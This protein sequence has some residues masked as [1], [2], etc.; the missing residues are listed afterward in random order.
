L[1]KFLQ[2]DPMADKYASATTYNYAFNNPVVINDPM[3]DDA[4]NPARGF[5]WWMYNRNGTPRNQGMQDAHAGGMNGAAWNALTYGS[6]MGTSIGRTTYKGPEGPSYYQDAAL[7]RS[8]QMSLEEYSA[9]YGSLS[10]NFAVTIDG[11]PHAMLIYQNEIDGASSLS[12]T[13]IDEFGVKTGDTEILAYLPKTDRFTPFEKFLIGVNEWNPVAHAYDLVVHAF[14]GTDR[15][16]NELSNED[17]GF[18]LLALAPFG[19]SARAFRVTKGGG[20]SLKNISGSLDDA[21]KLARNQPYGPNKNIFR[22]LPNSAQDTQ[23]LLEAQAGMGRN[24]NITLKDPRYLGWEKWHHSLG[25]N[26]N[27]SVV[28]YLRDPKT[29][30]LTDFKFK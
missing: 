23:A 30:F 8:N 13:P 1:G 5:Q 17:L 6:L 12:L 14:T 24:L 29:G 25:P 21:A 15:F 2:V 28:H 19:K 7:V 10:M 16:G 26:G 9:K 3:G 27:K 20:G 18:K 11:A 22:R 4:G